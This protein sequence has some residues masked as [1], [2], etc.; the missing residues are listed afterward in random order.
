MRRVIDEWLAPFRRPGTLILWLSLSLIAGLVGPFGTYGPLDLPLRLLLWGVALAIA[1]LIGALAQ[2]LVLRLPGIGPTR[3]SGLVVAAV[4]ALVL[5]LLAAGLVPA[6]AGTSV[7]LPTQ[8]EIAATV[9]FATLAIHAL[10]RSR[11]RFALPV[12]L[13]DGD[14]PAT[15]AA[16]PP[17]PPPGLPPE[18]LPEPRLLR[19]LDPVVRSRLVSISVRDHYVDVVTES[20]RAS[21]LMR[22]SDAMAETEGEAGAQIHRSHWV[23]RH[24]ARALERKGARL[25]LLLA[26][27]SRLPVSRA[28]RPVIDSWSLVETVPESDTTP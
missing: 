11:A 25:H 1:M 26:D 2:A 3:W 5:T 19:R 13:Q 22:L 7:P 14:T 4:L 8:A 6:F 9:F 20:G 27:G 15:A 23:A 21:L 24:A 18:T 16:G 10:T 28:Q 12:A 17:D